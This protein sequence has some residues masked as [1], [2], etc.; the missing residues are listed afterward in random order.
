MRWD[1]L[2][3]HTPPEGSGLMPDVAWQGPSRKEY[4]L[5]GVCPAIHKNDITGWGTILVL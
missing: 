2:F 5:K 4:G 3:Y 1:G